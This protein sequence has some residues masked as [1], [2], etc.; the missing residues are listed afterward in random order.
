LRNNPDLHILNGIKTQP[1][2]ELSWLVEYRKPADH[3][4]SA[5]TCLRNSPLLLGDTSSPLCQVFFVGKIYNRGE[6]DRLYPE[7]EGDQTDACRVVRAYLAAGEDSFHQISGRFSFVLFDAK[8]G[9]C[10]AVRDRMGIISLFY[11]ETPASIYFSDSIDAILSGGNISRDLNLPALAEY[12]IDFWP[13]PEETYFQSIY[14]V[15][16]ANVLSIDKHGLKKRHRYWDPVPFGSSPNWIKVS[17]LDQFYSLLERAVERGLE[18]GSSAIFLSGGLDSVSIAA[19]ASQVAKKLDMPVPLA[20]SLIFNNPEI[21]EEPVQKAVA[22]RLSLPQVIVPIRETLGPEGLLLSTLAETSQRSAPLLNI[23]APA[24]HHLRRQATDRG[25]GV[26]LSGNGGDEWLSVS[27]A[28]AADLIKQLK[29]SSLLGLMRNLLIS[30]RIPSW[31][32]A[33][34]VLWMYGARPVIGELGAKTLGSIS[35]RALRQRRINSFR[36]KYPAWI[37]PDP[38]IRKAIDL[39]LEESID[40]RMADLRQEGFYLSE[41]RTG[42][43]H[44]LVSIE[45]EESYEEGRLFGQVNYAPYLDYELVDFLYR[46]PPELLNRGGRSKGLIRQTLAEKF[47]ELGFGKLKKLTATTYFRETLVN[48]GQKAWQLFGGAVSLDQYGIVE[49]ASLNDTLA[50]IFSQGGSRNDSWRIWLT[51]NLEAWLRGKS[52][53]W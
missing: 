31:K 7:Y 51:L 36:R 6:L 1:R 28:Y 49:T 38:A 42:L 14:R 18:M 23:W 2:A 37:A 41:V 4:P 46:A 5:F 34:N 10:Y 30:Y 8:S 3:T 53:V 29:L 21:Y 13:K 47:P 50:K 39:H 27:I 9:V 16:P 40:A 32:M 35:P 26:I 48:E 15:P 33:K 19:I 24:Y 43:E 25:R 20:L 17:E 52:F 22:E 45:L 11:G 12:L 44:P